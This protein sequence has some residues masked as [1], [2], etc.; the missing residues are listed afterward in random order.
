[1]SL[2]SCLLQLLTRWILCEGISRQMEAMK[3]G[4]DAIFSSLHLSDLFHAD[5][6]EQLFCGNKSTQWETKVTFGWQSNLLK[7]HRS[8]CVQSILITSVVLNCVK[9]VNLLADGMAICSA[10]HVAILAFPRG[11]FSLE[12]CGPC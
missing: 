8:Q 9:C 6:L 2:A 11:F 4:F 1:M 7:D 10:T 5:E 3:E 12:P